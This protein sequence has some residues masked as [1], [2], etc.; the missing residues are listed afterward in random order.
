VDYEKKS[1]EFIPFESEKGK[2]LLA[3]FYEE[4]I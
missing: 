2:K 4:T 3:Q 1:I